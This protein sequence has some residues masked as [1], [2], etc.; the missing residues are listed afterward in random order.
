MCQKNPPFYSPFIYFAFF[1][2]PSFQIMTAEVLQKTIRWTNNEKAFSGE[3]NI[4]MESF[5]QTQKK[6][7]K[8][9]NLFAENSWGH[10]KGWPTDW[11]QQL[12][13]NGP[14]KS[15]RCRNQELGLTLS[16]LRKLYPDTNS[17]PRQKQASWNGLVVCG[18]NWGGDWFS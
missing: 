13:R 8:K 9:R 11:G 5:V 6:V 10:W 17:I 14:K 7:Q 12:V 1:F 4:E 15:L 16:S 3:S 2:S 18:E